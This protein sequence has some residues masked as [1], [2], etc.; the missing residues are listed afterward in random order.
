MILEIDLGGQFAPTK[1]GSKI[2]ITGM[3]DTCID[4]TVNQEEAKK[5]VT[6]A[7]TAE[8]PNGGSITIDGESKGVDQKRA[9]KK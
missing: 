4:G 7:M 2:V 9:T 6:I 5:V 3:I 8:L 1:A